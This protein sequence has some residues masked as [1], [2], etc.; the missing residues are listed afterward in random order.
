MTAKFLCENLANNISPEKYS[1]KFT[2]LITLN[3]LNYV[4]HKKNIAKKNEQKKE[5]SN[6]IRHA[7]DI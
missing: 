1:K 7:N 4:Q 6:F 5:K 3:E 2:F